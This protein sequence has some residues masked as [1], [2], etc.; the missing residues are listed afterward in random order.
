MWSQS[1]H[2]MSLRMWSP[3]SEKLGIWHHR[4]RWTWHWFSADQISPIIKLCY[5]LSLTLGSLGWSPCSLL[6]YFEPVKM[7]HG[8]LSLMSPG[9]V[10]LVE[11]VNT[12]KEV[13]LAGCQNLSWFLCAWKLKI[14]LRTLKQEQVR[15]QNNLGMCVCS[16]S[17]NWSFVHSVNNLLI[18]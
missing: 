17:F 2:I 12:Q 16:H 15:P 3:V 1:W 14:A 5:A 18:F 6:R 9:L 13:G 11:K 4:E 7:I 8:D 10:Y